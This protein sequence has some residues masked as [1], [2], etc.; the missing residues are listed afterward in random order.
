MVYSVIVAMILSFLFCFDSLIMSAG[1]LQATALN[2][3]LLHGGMFVTYLFPERGSFTGQ[4]LIVAILFPQ[5]SEKD[6][7]LTPLLPEPHN[8]PR[9]T[10]LVVHWSGAW[11]ALSAVLRH[12]NLQYNTVHHCYLFSLLHGITRFFEVLTCNVLV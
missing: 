5:S 9:T 7:E 11:G 12:G 2:L 8:S 4:F 10:L 3:D 6:R 1:P